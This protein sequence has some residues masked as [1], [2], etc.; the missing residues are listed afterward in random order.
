M[1]F[2][3]RAQGALEYIIIVS[4]AL[5]I[6]GVTVYFVTGSAGQQ[7]KSVKIQQC[8][9]TAAECDL[10][11]TGTSKATCPSCE[12]QCKF[13]N[14]SQVFN[15]ALYCCEMGREDMIYEGS[16]GCS[17]LCVSEQDCQGNELCCDSE[18]TPPLECSDE[19]YKENPGTC[20]E[21]CVPLSEQGTVSAPSNG[22]WISVQTP[23]FNNPIVFAS[24]NTEES[25][26]SPKVGEVRNVGQSSFEVKVCEHENSTGC[27][28]HPS[29]DV[30]YIEFEKN[31]LD[32]VSGVET[33][34][35]QISGGGV[36]NST[37]VN[38]EEDLS[39]NV[40][41]MTQPQTDNGEDPFMAQVHSLSSTSADIYLCDHAESSVDSCESH[42]TE[43][44]A[45]V[46]IDP[47]LNP[48]ENTSIGTT[49]VSDSNWNTVTYSSQFS[50]APAIVTTVQNNSGGEQPTPTMARNVTT[51]SMDIRYCEHDSGDTCDNHPQLDVG[52]FAFEP[53]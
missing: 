36:S 41:V 51:G 18:C 9:Q 21:A 14:G 8:R 2:S 5:A 43:T 52:W 10:K 29:E 24:S 25:S 6:A 22:G 38:F 42:V 17:N 44:V 7:R 49:T 45:W 31:K 40:V 1:R 3:G 33:G 27:D 30:G 39:S 28:S 48:F 19:E 4:I 32:N 46:A 50:E 34:T 12:E 47:D 23:D 15:G 37:T 16:P 20:D 13:Q 26:E 11:K 53:R 35:I